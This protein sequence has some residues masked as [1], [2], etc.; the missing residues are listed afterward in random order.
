MKTIKNLVC[1]GILLFLNGC[2]TTKP[3]SLAPVDPQPVGFPY[4]SPSPTPLPSPSV[5]PSVVSS[6]RV[7]KTSLPFG[8]TVV[9]PI[10]VQ[11]TVT[12]TNDGNVASGPIPVVFTPALPVFTLAAP[13]CLSNLVP[14]ASC[15]FN[16][17]FTPTTS[18]TYETMMNVGSS[19]VRKTVAVSGVGIQSNV[20]ITPTSLGF[21]SVAA[22]TS[23][24]MTL[25]V[26][27]SKGSASAFADVAGLPTG[28]SVINNTCAN[29]LVGAGL[30]CQITFAL[31]SS[32]PLAIPV[33]S[34]VKV[35]L[36]SIPISGTVNAPPA[37]LSLSYSGSSVPGASAFALSD[38]EA[39][40]SSLNSITVKNTGGQPADIS[41]SVFTGPV[42]V[43]DASSTCGATLAANQNC[44]VNI[45][46]SPTV[47]QSYSGTLQ[48]GSLSVGLTAK[49]LLPESLPMHEVFSDPY[50]N[51]MLSDSDYNF[52]CAQ[53]TNPIFCEQTRFRVFK[54]PAPN[55]LQIY[56]LR[57]T[58]T[59]AHYL[60]LQ[61]SEKDQLLSDFRWVM[62]DGLLVKVFPWVWNN[63]PALGGVIGYLATSQTVDLKPIYHSCDGI[64]GRPLSTT[65]VQAQANCAVATTD[66]NNNFYTLNY[67]QEI[68]PQIDG[69]YWRDM[70][71]LG[72]AP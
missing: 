59:K 63:N 34:S 68:Q 70:G 30:A 67:T 20:V 17:I 65:K 47:I 69:G 18:G 7:D 11:L 28:V 57:N 64:S 62:Q 24:S 14:L 56:E 8:N 55:R 39:G 6:L 50:H 66:Y 10:G 44:T 25:T 43:R 51:Y 3:L 31:S 9:A 13:S 58:L 52:Y 22:N 60:T 41:T 49:G 42:F 36:F 37:S 5:T 19:T 16:V 33:G 35:G 27:N 54:N 21:G 32:V 48:V 12:V 61:V 71:I 38:V 46:F 26:D 53:A 15:A 4:F 2:G 40:W 23:K 72:Y 45:L 29:G 1:L